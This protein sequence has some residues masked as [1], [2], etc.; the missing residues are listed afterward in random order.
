[1]KSN[2]SHQDKEGK[3][4]G[5]DV[6]KPSSGSKVTSSNTLPTLGHHV[7]QYYPVLAVFPE[8]S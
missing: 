7:E 6:A 3:H 2:P 4:T 1:M 8:I 5:T